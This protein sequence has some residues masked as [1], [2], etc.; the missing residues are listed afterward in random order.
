MRYNGTNR[1]LIEL[2]NNLLDAPGIAEKLG[3]SRAQ[4]YRLIKKGLP[5]IKVGG[6]T[7]FDPFEVMQWIKDQNK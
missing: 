6:N 5:V 1:R 4:V 2:S 7:R 3:V